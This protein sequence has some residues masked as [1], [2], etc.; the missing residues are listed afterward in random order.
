MHYSLSSRVLPLSRSMAGI[1]PHYEHSTQ[2]TEHSTPSQITSHHNTSQHIT[3]QQDT[4]PMARYQHIKLHSFR[5]VTFVYVVRTLSAHRCDIATRGG[6][7][8]D[9]ADERERGIETAP[10]KKERKQRRERKDKKKARPCRHEEK[11]L[12]TRVH[13]AGQDLDRIR[14]RRP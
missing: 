12:P 11:T 10:R 2:H 8:R 5:Y 4:K 1:S 3:G 14:P 9:S 13:D 6:R 7:G